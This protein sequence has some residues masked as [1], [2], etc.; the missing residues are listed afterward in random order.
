MY[1]ENI[2]NVEATS[3]K[4]NIDIDLYETEEPSELYNKQIALEEEM[5]AIA[6]ANPLRTL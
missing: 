1:E 6:V 2:E 3:S 5:Q 4:L